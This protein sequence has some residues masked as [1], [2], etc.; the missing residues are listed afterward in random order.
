MG[1]PRAPNDQNSKNN[2]LV[3]ETSYIP[4]M[5]HLVQEGNWY[6]NILIS[7]PHWATHGPKW[8]HLS[9]FHIVGY[10]MIHLVRLVR[11]AVLD[12]KGCRK[13]FYAAFTIRKA[14]EEAV[15]DRLIALVRVTLFVF[16]LL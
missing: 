15:G 7:G 8:S 4:S 10:N 11:D 9:A 1:S 2:V 12:K 16:L 13:Y 6:L 3:V 5:L 14:R